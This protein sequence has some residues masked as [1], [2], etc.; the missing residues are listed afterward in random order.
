MNNLSH[1]KDAGAGK[2]VFLIGNGPSLTPAQ[3]DAIKGEES[4]A[5]NRIVMIYP[6]TQWR[7]TYYLFTSDN[8]RHPAWGN[9]WSADI[10]HAAWEGA[11]TPIIWRRYAHDIAARAGTLPVN[12]IYLDTVSEHGAG[13]LEAFSTNAEA[14]IDKSGT[15]MNVALQLAYYLGYAETYLIGCDSNWRTA[16]N[17]PE[18]GDPNHFHPDYHAHI[19]D[20]VDEFRRMNATHVVAAHYFNL[21]GR[22]IWNLT[23]GTALTAYETKDFGEVT[24]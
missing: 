17:T 15:S 12:T 16:T 19:G 23:P 13:K 6:H 14:S 10:V 4:I 22:G 2:R 8:C 9:A 1:L 24:K 7:P 21:A 18:T 11:T 3:L 5:M 20:G